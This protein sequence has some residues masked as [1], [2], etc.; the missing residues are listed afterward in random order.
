MQKNNVIVSLIELLNTTINELKREGV[1]PDII[2]VGP[3]FKRYLNEE[4]LNMIKMKVYVIEELGSDAVI[5][6]SRYLGQLKKAS[7]RISI[8]P[9]IQESEWEKIL[10]EL[11][12]V[13]LE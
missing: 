13:K 6:D 2:L 5:A 7:R 4:V 11:P 9:L 3:E 8:E 12:E 10:E 1:E